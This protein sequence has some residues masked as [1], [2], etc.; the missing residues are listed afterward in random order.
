LVSGIK[1][2]T[3]DLTFAKS[4]PAP[5]GIIRHGKTLKQLNV[6]AARL[7][8]D[9]E[10]EL[11][12]DYESFSQICK[13][14]PLLEQVSVAFPSVSVVRAKTDSFVNFEVSSSPT[15]VS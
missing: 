10:D 5:A 6:H 7:P 1:T 3:V 14:C 15:I 13:A 12:Y 11:V 9:C 8:D 2:L 4:L